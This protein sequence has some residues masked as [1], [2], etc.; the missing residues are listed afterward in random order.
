[1]VH[2]Y[3]HGVLSYGQMAF[4]GGCAQVCLQL[5]GDLH[6]HFVTLEALCDKLW[7]ETCACYQNTQRYF[8]DEGILTTSPFFVQP[9]NLPNFD[10]FDER[11]PYCG[12]NMLRLSPIV[13]GVCRFPFA[14]TVK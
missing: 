12:G 6:P 7:P 3:R 2:E 10:L 14:G 8:E 5:S 4:G 1:M 11:Q 9:R 13:G